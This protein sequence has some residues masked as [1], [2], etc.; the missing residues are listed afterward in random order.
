MKHR[1]TFFIVSAFF[2]IIFII[3]LSCNKKDSEAKPITIRWW[4][5]NSDK[6]SQ[7]VFQNIANEFEKTNP[8]VIIKI[9]MLDNMEYKPKLELDFAAGDP[10]DIFHS[11]GGGGLAEQVEAGHLRDITSYVKSD[12]WQSKISPIA[13]EIYSHNGKIYGFPHDLGAVGFWYNKELLK[14]VGYTSFP[15]TWHDFYKLCDRLKKSGITP[16]SIGIAD[17]WPVM[18]YWVYLAMRIGG[19]DLFSD[20]HKGNIKFNNPDLIKAGLIMQDLFKHGYFQSSSI[21]DDFITQS[22]YMGDGECAMQ[23]MGQW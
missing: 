11:W 2:V 14:K 19:E 23:L 16:I 15:E 13:L 12:N 8:D 4:H 20:I 17:R 9:T 1:I 21:G 22:R 3:S 7:V 10:P 5:I 18:Y 6:Q